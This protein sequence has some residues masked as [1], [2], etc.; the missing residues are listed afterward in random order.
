MSLS[1]RIRADLPGFALELDF[2]CGTGITAV[3]GHSGA[4][5]STLLRVLAGLAPARGEI[6][7]GQTTWLDSARGLDLRPEQRRA[8]LVFQHAALFPHLSVRANLD[9]GYRRRPAGAA[10]PEPVAII[11]ALGLA[12]ML[13]RRPDSLSGGERQRLALGRT[14]LAAP[15]LLLLDEPLSALDG[16]TRRQLA[17]ALAGLCRQYELTA[18]LVS[19][20]VDEAMHLANDALVLERGRLLAQGRLTDLLADLDSPLS[21]E[22]DAGVVLETRVA[23]RHQA[24]GLLRLEFAGGALWLPDGGQAPGQALR[25]R[26]HARDISLALSRPADSSILNI[27]PARVE[28]LRE[29]GVAQ[30]LVRL[31]CAGQPLLARI[32]KKSA[33]DLG[34]APG[35]EVHA[36]IK[37]LAVVA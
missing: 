34:L 26:L 9:Y 33:Q 6:R 29:D 31:D 2:D 19:H 35:R 32:T 14:L 27:L 25:V 24:W 12:P 10:G 5:K 23:E 22:P 21:A 20:D 3:L 17:D 11:D 4:G 36:Q 1:A 8:G 28:A 7:V 15:R 18:L 16:P 13:E 37:G 30:V